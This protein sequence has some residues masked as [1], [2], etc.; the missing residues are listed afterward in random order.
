MRRKRWSEAAQELYKLT[1]RYPR[2]PEVFHLQSILAAEQKDN[3]ALLPAAQRWAELD[4]DD[5]EAILNLGGACMLNVR[6]MMALHTFRQ[7]LHRWP[8]HARAAGIRSSIA[9]L[10]TGMEQILQ[11]IGL[12]EIKEAEEVALWHE[13]L[14]TELAQ[15]H[16][17]EALALAEKIVACAPLFAA[18]HNNVSLIYFGQGK[19]D[20]AIATARHVLQEIDPD[21][22]HAQANLIHFLCSTG[23]PEKARPLA[24]RLKANRAERVDAWV[25][26]AVALSF[27]GDDTGVL[28]TFEQAIE[29]GRLGDPT[30]DAP[31]LHHLAAAATTRLGREKE[32]IR[33]WK[34]ALKLQP[35]LSLAQENLTDMKKPVGQRHAPWA[36]DLNEWLSPQIV[37]QVVVTTEKSFRHGASEQKLE[38]TVRRL[39]RQHPT[40]VKLIPTLLARG[41]PQGREFAFHLARIAETPETVEALASFALSPHGPDSLRFEVARFLSQ[42]GYWPRGEMVT[43]WTR[44]EQT[45][46]ILLDFEISDEPKTRLKG[47][48]QRLGDQ[49]LE[50]LHNFD[51]VTA[52]ALLEQ[53]LK[54]EP[55]HPTLLMNLASA[56]G[57]QGDIE[58]A[59]T[60]VRQTVEI[61]PDYLIGRCEM[62]RF[63][64][65]NGNLDE[66]GEWLDPILHEQSFHT[67]E[68]VAFCE[69]RID[70]ELAHD[71]RDAARS[72]LEMWER[73]DSDHPHFPIWKRKVNRR[74][75][76]LDRLRR[77]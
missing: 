53:A 5:P 28:E 60:L 64:I 44:G 57:L 2:S 36:F 62:A 25:K 48:A 56:Y 23:H 20:K 43:M 38:Q 4:P 67:S 33:Y 77:R 17:D 7:F 29:A 30:A 21:N 72:W 47:R 55:E 19:L 12:A 39:L 35:G 10:A 65:M 11:E 66:A 58:Q 54:I 69:A 24:E 34:S 18:P 22:L 37:N 76:L 46:M 73:V 6:P 74:E 3:R 71:R 14:Q 16:Y 42:K 1:Q 15:T 61:D 31:L 41:G 75:G 32:A 68:F 51:G 26:K 27:L 40:I 70:L 52:Q 59:R 63:A 45:E 49:A 13:Q 8:D 50:A 9:E